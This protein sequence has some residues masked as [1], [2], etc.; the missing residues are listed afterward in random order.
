M[1]CH[2]GQDVTDAVA[3]SGSDITLGSGLIKSSSS[4]SSR[5]TATLAGPL[6]NNSNSRWWVSETRRRYIPELGDVVIGVVLELLGESYAVDI[7]APRLASLDLL[8]FDGATRRNCPDLE[9]GA[10]VFARV[11]RAMNDVEPQLTCMAVSNKK[12]WTSGEA[13]FGELK[14]GMVFDVKR[15]TCR[16]LAASDMVVVPVLDALGSA[17]PFELCVGLNG[18]V[19]VSADHDPACVVVVGKALELCGAGSGEYGEVKALVRKL[20]RAAGIAPAVKKK[21][22][23]EEEEEEEEDDDEMLE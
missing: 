17:F 7:N 12:D 3:S 16:L 15:S 10:L 20:V 5:V 18:K 21:K 1:I 4:S 9:P 6:R 23:R 8:A 22:A 11:C 13:A 2:P 14:G 19:W